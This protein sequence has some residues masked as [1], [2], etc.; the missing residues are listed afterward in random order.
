MRTMANWMMAGLTAGAMVLVA[1]GGGSS[2]STS[3]G[4]G[5]GSS[6]GGESQYAGPI[7]STNVELGESKYQARC[8]G[9]HEN[10]SPPLANLAFTAEHMRRQIREGGGSMPAIGESRLA[11]DELEALLAYLVT[12]QAVT[13]GAAA[14]AAN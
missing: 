12:I 10:G 3:E 13:D 5:G 14:P 11:A 9:C 2:G 6:S 4:G 8:A 1:C 7:G